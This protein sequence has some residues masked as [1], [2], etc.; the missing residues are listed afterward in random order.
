MPHRPVGTLAACIALLFVVAWTTPASAKD[1][2]LTIAGGYSP[3]GNQVSLEKNVLYYQR[4][5]RDMG[6]ADA[7]HTLLFAD[8]HDKGRDLQFMDPD[9]D[10]PKPSLLLATIANQTKYLYH[11]YR[12][13]TL[14]DVAGPSSV[15]ELDK[16][17]NKTGSKLGPDDRVFIY[18]TA[19]GGRGAS[20]TKHNTK[21]MLWNNQSIYVRDFVARLDSIPNETPVIIIMVQC[22]SG[23]FA[24]VIFEEGDPAKGLSKGRRCGFYATVHT[25][26]AAGCTPD[27][28]EA[29]Y[30][31]YSTY[32]WEALYGK[33]RLGKA[34][35]R[36]D[37]DGDGQVSFAEA[38]AYTI[39]HS[40]TID[41]PIK[42]SD[43]FLRKFSETKRPKPAAK[44]D[45]AKKTDEK[46]GQPKPT[47]PVPAA[48][49]EQPKG[50]DVAPALVAVSVGQS[51]VATA[52]ASPA[53]PAPLLT[54]DSKYSD[55]LAAATPIDRVVLE[56]LSKNL[57]LKGDNRAKAARDLA[58]KTEDERKKLAGEKSKLGKDAETIR[59][60]IYS[61]VAKNYPEIRNAWH[62]RIHQAIETEGDQ[63]VK[64]IEGHKDYK[65]MVD[66]R[67]KQNKIERKR[68]DLEHKWVK[69][70]RVLHLL[71]NAALAGNLY[72]IAPDRQSDYAALVER[73]AGHLPALSGK[74][75]TQAGQDVTTTATP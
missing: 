25:R 29:N 59:R 5:L 37:Y 7:P 67:E 26:P 73:E 12:S 21:L 69:T 55:L 1:Y 24:N 49:V 8:G 3:T 6:R 50:K 38:H 11:Q 4:M 71:E 47:P 46:K 68:R 75:V 57:G 10:I 64:M 61:I 42:T 45:D 9:F 30:R 66:L 62:P 53:P 52:P 35:E 54:Q 27:I 34:I 70:Q 13:H 63:I 43:A 72:Q 41:I 14:P 32:F 31:E 15:A 36:P 39:I 16:W 23:G 2:F 18:V 44:K 56:T 51:P 60:A 33:T 19:H 28:N 22:F 17:I 40:D 74:S 65:K 48:K 58:K 20:K